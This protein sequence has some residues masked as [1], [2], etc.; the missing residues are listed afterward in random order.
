MS[1]GNE[2]WTVVKGDLIL[3]TK[4]SFELQD[5]ETG[6]TL[7]IKKGIYKKRPDGKIVVKS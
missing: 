1:N 4:D 5:E 7:T 6:K 3:E 2:R